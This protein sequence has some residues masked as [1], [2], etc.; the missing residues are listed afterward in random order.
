MQTDDNWRYIRKKK[1]VHVS[2]KIKQ[3]VFHAAGS[4]QEKARLPYVDY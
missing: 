2:D 3:S 1:Q 4:A